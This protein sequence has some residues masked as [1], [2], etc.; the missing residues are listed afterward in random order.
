LERFHLEP[1]IVDFHA[2]IGM[3]QLARGSERRRV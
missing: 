1:Y 3:G 2:D